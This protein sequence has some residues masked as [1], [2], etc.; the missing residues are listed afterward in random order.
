MTYGQLKNE[1]LAL[2]FETD[3]PG[4]GILRSA[5][6]R[7]LS[8]IASERGN[9]GEV[10]IGAD[11][12]EGRKIF[13]LYRHRSRES[14]RIPLAGRACCFAVSGTGCYTLTAGDESRTEDFSGD[15]VV[16][17]GFLPEGGGEIAFSGEH[18][19]S[20]YDLTVFSD[21]AGEDEESIPAPDGRRSVRMTDL[22]DDFLAFASPACRKNGETL[23]GVLLEN[24]VVTIP[25][26]LS[27]EIFLRYRR[28]PR[29]PLGNEDSEVLDL[30]PEC[31][32]ALALLVASYVW[33]DDDADK[34]DRYLSAYREQ[35]AEVRR[36]EAGRIDP[37]YESV[38]AW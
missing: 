22:C 37:R 4:D 9:F 30:P 15:G 10:R 27:G 24:G 23:P 13:A 16:I 8:S 29:T 20:V 28:R 34:A 12:P 1:V 14:A 19:F 11:L 31:E 18:F 21:T 25:A 38:N 32:H 33:L 26:G 36:T 2:G 6:A 3:L 35:M 7:A 5:L 17:R